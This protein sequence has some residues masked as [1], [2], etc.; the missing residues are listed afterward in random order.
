[1]DKDLKNRGKE[2]RIGR[3]LQKSMKEFVFAELSTDYMKKCGTDSFM[4][5]VPVPFREED[6]KAAKEGKGIATIRISENMAFVIG[7]DPKFS[8]GDKYV[9]FIELLWGGKFCDGL[10]QS[11]VKE[12]E[13]GNFETA[14]IYLRACLKI[15]PDNLEAM[16]TYALICRELYLAGHENGRDDEYIGRFKAEAME[17]FEQTTIEYPDF[18][19]AYFYLGYAYLNMGMYGKAD[20]S[21]KE[22]MRLTDPAAEESCECGHHHGHEEESCECGHDHVHDGEVCDCGHHHHQHGDDE[23]CHGENSHEHEAYSARETEQRTEI[24]ARLREIADPVQI[25]KGYTAIISGR[26]E[27]GIEL[28]EP[29]QTGKFE[30]WWPLYYYLGT[31]YART[32][33]FPE[34]EKSLQKVLSLNASHIDTMQ[35]LADLY[36][37]LGDE[38]NM[39]KYLKK[40]ELITSQK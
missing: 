16:Y 32:G 17:Y 39:H 22:F 1:M 23:H 34:A 36:K 29:F 10:V 21:W 12:A 28:L 2:D 26:Y 8:Y 25:E 5:N 7:I 19:E 35:E 40:I 3:Y 27:Q 9:H 4:K 15:E 37:H 31:A 20:A 33:R 30:R 24:S 38:V 18:P 6:L 11:G 14:C 13:Q